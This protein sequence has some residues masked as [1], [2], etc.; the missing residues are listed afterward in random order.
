MYLY[1]ITTSW[2]S[3]IE[4]C[5]VILVKITVRE[6]YKEKE[7]LLKIKDQAMKPY[8]KVCQH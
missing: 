7:L 6:W 2:Q 5:Y 8:I 4:T 3:N 1:D